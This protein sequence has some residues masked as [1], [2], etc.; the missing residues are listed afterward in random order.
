M[1]EVQIL[2]SLQRP[3]KICFISSDGVKRSLLCKPKDDLRKDLRLLELGSLA[4]IDLAPRFKIQIYAAI[5]LKEETGIIEWVDSTVSLRSILSTLYKEKGI[6]INFP[7]FKELQ[8]APNFSSIFLSD[9]LSKFLSKV[10]VT[11]SLLGFRLSST[12]GF[13][14]ALIIQPL[15]MLVD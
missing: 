4:N 2:P 6:G 5:P 12:A 15:G 8:K 13:I 9:I 7:T 10:F 3:K 14:V 11:K 1:D